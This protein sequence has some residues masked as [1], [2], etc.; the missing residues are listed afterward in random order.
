M[1][2]DFHMKDVGKDITKAVTNLT[3]SL[4]VLD[5]IAETGQPNIAHEVG[6]LNGALAL[7]GNANHKNNLGR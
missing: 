3:K 1:N 7:L 2:A 4:M 5:K 6:M